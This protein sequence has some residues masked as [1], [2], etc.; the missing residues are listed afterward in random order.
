[1]NTDPK[2]CPNHN[3][4]MVSSEVIYDNKW[5]YGEPIEDRYTF[6]CLACG[7]THELTLKLKPTTK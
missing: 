5:C 6:K 3:M 4:R 2:T 7:H 1:M